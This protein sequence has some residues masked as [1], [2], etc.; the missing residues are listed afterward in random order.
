MMTSIPS[1]TGV[2]RADEERERP[3]RA[4]GEVAEEQDHRLHRD[5]ADQVPGRELEVPLRR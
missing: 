2:S 5:S 4:D 1:S 3:G